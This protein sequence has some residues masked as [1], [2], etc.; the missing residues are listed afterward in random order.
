M[1]KQE[2]T[3]KQIWAAKRCFMN[4]GRLIGMVTSLNQLAEMPDVFSLMERQLLAQAYRT[5]IIVLNRYDEQTELLRNEQA[6]GSEQ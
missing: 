1:K 3:A 6:K 2:R 5:I 4:K